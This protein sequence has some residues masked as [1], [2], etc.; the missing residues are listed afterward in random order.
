MKSVFLPEWPDNPYQ[1]LLAT[2]LVEHGIA[3]DH[4]A[5]QR[6]FYREVSHRRAAILHLHSI[7]QLFAYA[8][9]S[10]RAEALAVLVLGQLAAL[11]GRGVRLAWTA[12]ELQ[13]HERRYPSLSR[14]ATRAVARLVDV[15]FVHCA[16]SRDELV[17]FAGVDPHRVHL[18]S[19]PGYDTYY[20]NVLT[21]DQARSRLGLPATAF[22]FGF[23]GN[24][25][26]YKGVG[27]LLDAFRALGP[28]SDAWLVVAGKPWDEAIRVD[29]ERRAG[30]HPRIRLDARFVPESEVQTILNGADVMV[31]PF[32][33]VGSSGSVV[34][35]MS[36]GRPCI[37]PRVGCLPEWLSPDASFFYA[38]DDPGGLV[39]VMSEAIERRDEL[40][41]MGERCR[42]R[43][44]AWTWQDAARTT[45]EV[46]ETL[47]G[48]L[49]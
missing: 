1:R 15:V 4:L 28:D 8:S 22:V 41:A 14:R 39:A 6:W 29:L 47:V 18:V 3:V 37:V 26:G 35:A 13:N 44:Q 21:R 40:T 34:L 32:R 31:L 10:W 30:G 7:D 48:R 42:R 2:H 49:K 38:A 11:R 12:H 5:R 43:A 9:S 46:Y 20:E 36:F 17:Q 23:F 27:D 19:H 45:A 25:R 16:R 24:L 33:A